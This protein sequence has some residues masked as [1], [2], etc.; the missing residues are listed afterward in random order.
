[1]NRCKNTNDEI[2]NKWTSI[3]HSLN[4]LGNDY[5]KDHSSW[6]WS[7]LIYFF[8]IN[9]YR[10]DHLHHNFFS[11]RSTLCPSKFWEIIKTQY[12]K[13]S[14]ELI[15]ENHRKKNILLKLFESVS[16]NKNIDGIFFRQQ[17]IELEILFRQIFQRSKMKYFLLPMFSFVFRHQWV[18]NL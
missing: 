14:E 7:S 11:N 12:S 8:D 3:L 1:M 4:S 9:E 10:M 5:F 6:M 15:D 16:L 2:S 18:T 13:M 17:S